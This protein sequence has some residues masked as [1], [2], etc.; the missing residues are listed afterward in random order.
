MMKKK[1]S[2]STEVSVLSWCSYTVKYRHRSPSSGQRGSVQMHSSFPS[3]SWTKLSPLNECHYPRS[4]YNPIMWETLA[5]LMG[6][7]CQTIQT[8]CWV[9][10]L[11]ANSTQH[12]TAQDPAVLMWSHWSPVMS[13]V[14][15]WSDPP[16]E[17]FTLSLSK[18]AI[19][20]LWC[21]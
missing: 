21:S 15:H 11:K 19:T 1:K 20:N 10:H 16:S 6:F 4:L 14:L 9:N 7:F 12:M 18:T 3:L 5:A 8:H 17:P 13:A 2:C